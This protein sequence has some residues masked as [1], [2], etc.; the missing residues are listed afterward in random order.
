MMSRRARGAY[1][2]IWIKSNLSSA[3]EVLIRC[4]SSTYEVLR[5]GVYY[6]GAQRCLLEP[7]GPVQLP[8]AGRFAVAACPLRFA[9]GIP[10]GYDVLTRQSPTSGPSPNPKGIWGGEESASAID[11]RRMSEDEYVRDSR[12]G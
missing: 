5:P 8:L 7:R 6:F 2:A 9:P 1:K 12:L 4:L 10:Y 3:Y 11:G